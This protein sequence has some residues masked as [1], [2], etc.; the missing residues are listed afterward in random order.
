M[1]SNEYLTF[2]VGMKHHAVNLTA[3]AYRSTGCGECHTPICQKPSVICWL[4][5]KSRHNV[6]GLSVVLGR[7]ELNPPIGI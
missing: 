7:I 6:D 4:V 3:L 5:S 1:I 2:D